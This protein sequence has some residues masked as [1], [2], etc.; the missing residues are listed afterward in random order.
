MDW[1]TRLRGWSLDDVVAALGQLP[2]D[3]QHSLAHSLGPFSPSVS[4]QPMQAPL[5]PHL[6]SSPQPAQPVQPVRP[7]QPPE[8]TQAPPWTVAGGSIAWLLDELKLSSLYAE[9]FDEY[10]MR[11]VQSLVE[12][13]IEGQLE[14]RLQ[15]F[16]I[17]RDHRDKISRLALSPRPCG[18]SGE[19]WSRR[20]LEMCRPLHA[21]HMGCENMGPLLYSLIRFVK[22]RRVLEVG[23]GYTSIWILQ[24]LADNDAELASCA[25]AVEADGYLVAQ[26]EWMVDSAASNSDQSETGTGNAK[27]DSSGAAAQDV[28]PGCA[29]KGPSRLHTIDDMGAAEGG[30]RGTAHLVCD[31]AAALGLTQHLALHAG[32]AYQLA[33]MSFAANVGDHTSTGSGGDGGDGDGGHCSVQDGEDMLDMLWL[34]FGLGT[35]SRIDEFLDAWWPRLRSGGH[36]LMH[37]TLTNA[38]TRAW[39]ESRREQMRCP[40]EGAG[41]TGSAGGSTQQRGGLGV[42]ETVSLLEPHKRYQNSVSIFQKRDGGWTEPLHTTYP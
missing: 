8:S 5:Y 26:A 6:T 17:T 4:L 25:R 38:V 40:A 29:R 21:Q 10:E 19:V 1:G 15:E 7:P 31:T 9:T 11:K 12:L 16:G 36:L 20:F 34:D 3:L 42:F 27:A 24:A 33:G 39:L 32:D 18:A 22:P 41:G 30:N 2:T 28:I 14:E 13:H 35:G 23:A 37:S